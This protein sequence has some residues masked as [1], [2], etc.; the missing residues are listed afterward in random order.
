[1]AKERSELMK[2]LTSIAGCSA[3]LLVGITVAVVIVAGG[4]SGATPPAPS[5]IS[6]GVGVART[7]FSNADQA[8]LARIGATGAITKVGAHDGIAFYSIGG[9][10]GRCFAFGWEAQGGLSGGCL[11][12]GATTPAV[13]DM[14][15][16]VMNPANGVWLLDT[17]QGI[18]ADGI[19]DV[20]FVDAN[21]VVHTAP[22]VSN[23]YRLAGQSFAG[24]PASELVG[25]DASG[26]RVF[27]EGLGTP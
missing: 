3:A 27:T 11:A 8:T 25:L 16:I 2:R 21:G 5:V 22:V 23:V 9:G 10:G 18:A 6:S 13:L 7:A 17:L 1:M 14:S 19:A 26:K 24:G 12:A 15:S 20:G 4:A